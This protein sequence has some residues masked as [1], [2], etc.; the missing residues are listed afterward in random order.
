MKN[1]IEDFINSEYIVKLNKDEFSDKMHL[2]SNNLYKLYKAKLPK[3]RSNRY[4]RFVK[5]YDC[6]I[7]ECMFLNVK[8]KEI[9]IIFLDQIIRKSNN[10]NEL[11]LIGYYFNDCNSLCFVYSLESSVTQL[12]NKYFSE[13][14][15][16]IFKSDEKDNKNEKF[17]TKL[18]KLQVILNIIQYVKK[19]HDTNQFYLL[20]HPNTIMWNSDVFKDKKFENDNISDK[21]IKLEELNYVKLLGNYV[22]SIFSNAHLN[23]N[24]NKQFE[25]LGIKELLQSDFPILNSELNKSTR[26]LVLKK[27]YTEDIVNQI[28]LYDTNNFL[29]SN[30]LSISKIKQYFSVF[31]IEKDENERKISLNKDNNIDI[32]Y[33]QKLDVYSILLLI[34]YYFIE[35]LNS[36]T[37]LN[38]IKL[39]SFEKIILKFFKDRILNDQNYQ[40]ALEFVHDLDI[41]EFVIENMTIEIQ[42]L[43]SIDI[44]YSNFKNL[45]EKEINSTK[46][47]IM[48]EQNVP[49]LEKNHFKYTCENKNHF[50][51]V[52]KTIKQIGNYQ[53]IKHDSE[54]VEQ[55]ND[56]NVEIKLNTIESNKSKKENESI[57]IKDILEQKNIND[58][59]EEV[60]EVE[61]VEEI[62]YT[63]KIEK[64]D[65]R[66]NQFD[67]KHMNNYNNVKS[68][69]GGIADN[70]I[71]DGVD[72]NSKLVIKSQILKIKKEVKK[73]VKKEMMK[74]NKEI[75]ILDENRQKYLQNKDQLN[76]EIN[77][78]ANQEIQISNFNDNNHPQNI[79]LE[80]IDINESLIQ[81]LNEIDL[82]RDD[83]NYLIFHPICMTLMCKECLKNHKCEICDIKSLA[84]KDIEYKESLLICNKLNNLRSKKEFL[85][86]EVNF[87]KLINMELYNVIFAYDDL[88]NHYVSKYNLNLNNLFENINS[89]INEKYNEFL[90]AYRSV[91]TNTSNNKLEKLI[92]N[93]SLYIHEQMD[94]VKE[95]ENYIFT[96]NSMKFSKE[97]GKIKRLLK[98]YHL[99]YT[100]LTTE[101]LSKVS[102][103]LR[104]TVE[105]HI[106]K[107][108]FNYDIPYLSV[109]KTNFNVVM[110][111][112]Y[113]FKKIIC[114][115]LDSKS[116]YI[117][118]LYSYT[119]K[120]GK[121][122]TK[123]YLNQYNF[124]YLEI[125][126]EVKNQ[127][128]IIRKGSNLINLNNIIII[129]GGS[130]N[131]KVLKNCYQ[132]QYENIVNNKE[133]EVVSIQEMIN[134][135]EEH[136][137]IKIN[138]YSFAVIGGVNTNTC[139]MYNIFT[140][141]W[142]PLGKLLNA[143]SN[144]LLALVNGID[145]YC[146]F[147]IWMNNKC[148]DIE[149]LSINV[150]DE[151][152]EWTKVEI[153][154]SSHKNYFR[155]FSL[156]INSR[157]SFVIVG[158]LNTYDEECLQSIKFDINE[159]T[160]NN[161]NEYNLEKKDKENPKN[162][163][164]NH[165]FK[166]NSVIEFK[167]RFYV[168]GRE[169]NKDSELS[170]VFLKK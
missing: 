127:E 166:D 113:M 140:N 146:L 18:L 5:F 40:N 98:E 154:N 55:I 44:L 161:T 73:E 87:N 66:K 89:K 158:G 19:L 39:F 96:F 56:N 6:L 168:F 42:N 57:I 41:K 10:F 17:W 162:K 156:I 8:E 53:E 16:F 26:N 97:L 46:M 165:I 99:I 149:K 15:Q 119:S 31:E 115:D 85:E 12:N 122:D 76:D 65:V 134:A 86:S 59:L 88:T 48:K 23:N 54:N 120:S 110:S 103:R 47:K 84:K 118:R 163:K 137:S 4:C 78:N 164:K 132:V 145:L 60:V 61:E 151:K 33:L 95:I 11:S 38:S 64:L 125:K 157:N 133:A 130:N 62:K 105:N 131:V 7:I 101:G 22:Y 52:N 79:E 143:K 141:Q 136:S 106:R 129:T 117:S 3:D 159:C 81:D 104:K 1:D 35:N 153:S 69:V 112:D 152:Y 68:L 91:Q 92:F 58:Q 24:T 36:T 116:T 160:F 13:Y 142:K 135:R 34:S 83:P 102:E 128:Y 25:E 50:E 93:I 107:F 29:L 72:C 150:D 144:T 147:G 71:N 139:E 2:S 90:N 67:Q 109:M 100:A 77:H 124:N 75:P 70:E 114:Y 51:M 126:Q 108:E 80:H 21:K 14:H 167:N 49:N 148:Y 20:L 28:T 138:M 27:N 9:D 37:D 30:L 74:E 121:L 155:M 123:M 45:Y 63:Q 169:K 82:I 43:P 111:I 170:I 94:I 32:N